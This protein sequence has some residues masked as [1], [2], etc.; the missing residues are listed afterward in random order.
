VIA[1]VTA[2]ATERPCETAGSGGVAEVVS[3]LGHENLHDLDV[4]HA[5]IVRL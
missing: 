4:H 2:V 3:T 5:A 1:V